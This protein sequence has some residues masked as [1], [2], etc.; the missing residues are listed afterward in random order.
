MALNNTLQQGGVRGRCM[1]GDKDGGGMLILTL[2]ATVYKRAARYLL[3]QH[4]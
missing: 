1:V 2:D 3:C 4:R